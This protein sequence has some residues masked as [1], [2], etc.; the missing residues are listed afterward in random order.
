MTQHVHTCSSIE[1][2]VVELSSKSH[3]DSISLTTTP[4]E[5][6]DSADIYVTPLLLFQETTHT[7]T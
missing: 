1:I 6:K 3:S 2:Q 5:K 7:Q 4:P